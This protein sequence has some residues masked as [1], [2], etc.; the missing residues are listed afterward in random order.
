MKWKNSIGLEHSASELPDLLDS[1]ADRARLVSEDIFKEID[2]Q[3]FAEHSKL[4]DK[5]AQ[6][7]PILHPIRDKSNSRM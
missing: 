5:I 1:R 4:I 2:E 3:V 7:S 6:P